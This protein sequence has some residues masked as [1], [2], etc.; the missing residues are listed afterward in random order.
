MKLDTRGPQSADEWIEDPGAR[1]YERAARWA[2]QNKDLRTAIEQCAAALALQPLDPSLGRL[3]DQIVHAAK[4]PLRLVDVRGDR[5]FFGTYAARAR[6]LAKLG[7]YDEAFQH[8]FEAAAF[9]PRTP[10]LTW[11]RDWL[12]DRRARRTRPEVVA[13]GLLRFADVLDAGDEDNARA[14]RAIA[15]Y[16]VKRHADND[17][18]RVAR[19]R[20]LGRL[21]ETGEALASLAESSS[22]E[23]AVARA[24]VWREVGDDAKRIEALQD[25]TRVAPTEGS[26]WLDL[27][28][29]QLDDGVLDQAAAALRRALAI[30]DSAHGRALLEHALWLEDGIAPSSDRTE[31]P[32]PGLVA[33]RRAY[34]QSLPDPIDPVIAALRS[35]DQRCRDGR[36]P[37]ATVRVRADRSIAP[38][39]WRAFALLARRHGLGD[40]VL[41]VIGNQARDQVGELWRRRGTGYEVATDPP[42]EEYTRAIDRVRAVPFDRAAWRTIASENALSDPQCFIQAMPHVSSPPRDEDVT[43][44]V[45]AH[46]VASAILCAHASARLDDRFDALEAVAT[47]AYDDWLGAAALIGIDELATLEPGARARCEQLL[48]DLLPADG[49]LLAPNVLALSVVGTSFA[50]RSH[51]QPFLKLRARVRNQ[52]APDTT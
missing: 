24:A 40:D 50:R 35:I 33:D 3:F 11:G 7:R 23:A 38:S 37:T 20:L 25:A 1:D 44:W 10:F 22:W 36:V 52:I 26:A 13:A 41:D 16:F 48:V 49:E 17:A 27:G 45:H 43:K 29:A 34:T 32:V 18:L 21:G 30:E 51:R 14:A 19:A 39:A 2:L 31:H 15:E 28:A 9:S 46:Q 6:V 12:S 4:G 5:V 47:G 42:P 8:L